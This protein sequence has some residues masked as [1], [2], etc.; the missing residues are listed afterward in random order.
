MLDEEHPKV[1][2]V[3]STARRGADNP[4]GL[5]AISELL[6]IGRRLP[7]GT[8][9]GL[10]NSD[11][12]FRGDQDVL[13][14]IFEAGREGCVFANR[15]E[16]PISSAEPHLPYLYGYDLFVV[17]NTY[18]SPQ[19]LDQFRIGAP[20]WD[21]LFLYMML[22]R[23]VPLILLGG[24]V[25]SH[26][27]HDQAWSETSWM[28]GLRLVARQL[29]ELSEEEGPVAALLGHICRSFEEGAIPGYTINAI[30]SAFGVVLGTAMVGCISTACE[31]ALWFDSVDEEQGYL[32]RGRGWTTSCEGHLQHVGESGH[33][34]DANRDIAS[35]RTIEALNL[36]KTS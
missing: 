29:R 30:T 9:F 6:E 4:K 19:E 13:S 35:R 26:S 18:V 25:I 28:A 36:R 11:V 8:P 20:W 17:N 24:P 31:R 7:P 10:V 32:P 23:E 2:F 14:S 5:P 34:H 27:T 12:E 3:T 1:E 33:E 16:R 21:Y 15:Y 22:V